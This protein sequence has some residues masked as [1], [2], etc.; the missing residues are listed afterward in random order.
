MSTPSTLK[1]NLPPKFSNSFWSSPDYRRGVEAVYSR[2]QIGLDENASI[3]SFVDQ[4]TSIEYAHAEQ[5]AKPSPTPSFS[6]PLF[7][8]AL[9]EGSSKEAR[10]F[11]ASASSASRAFRVVEA[12]AN[13]VQA[14]AHAKVAR[15]LERTVLMPFGRWSEEHREKIQSSW[16][17]V[18][19]NLHRFERQKGEVSADV[20]RL[21]S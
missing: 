18:D 13:K 21:R 14:E 2:L 17:F 4:R 3:L 10:T 19:A 16:D 6:A 5:L 1:I 7:K 11:A 12:E 8:N 15:S 9:R 20:G